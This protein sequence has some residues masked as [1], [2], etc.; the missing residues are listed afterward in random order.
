MKKI[1]S[2]LVFLLMT[3]SIAS[4]QDVPSQTNQDQTRIQKK[5]RLN[6]Q[7]HLMF[8]DGKLYRMQE[9][10][11]TQVQEQVRL[12]NGTVVNPDGSYQLQN[13][14]RYQLRD[15]ECL[16]MQGNMYK[17]EKRFNK[18]HMM[19]QKQMDKARMKSMHRNMRID[20]GKG[21]V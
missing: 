7:E 1:L 8:Q 19:T 2:I 4:A 6:Q 20:R 18:R 12:E 10:V 15:G 16:D 14:E 5:D 3:G 13:Q 11:R 17:N 21:R 9:G